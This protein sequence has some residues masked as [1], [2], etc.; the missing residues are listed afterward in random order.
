M[1]LIDLID[2]PKSGPLIGIDPGSK[3]LGI[4]ASDSLRLIASP[5][6]TIQRSKLAKD[7]AALFAL[8]DDRGAV[9]LVIGLPLNMDGSEGPRVQSARALAR[10]IARARDIPIAMQDERLSTAQ[11]TRAMLEADLSR[12]RRAEIIDASAA[13]I[14]LQTALDQLA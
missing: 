11:A 8:Y 1:A 5:V 10:N 12:A 6:T 9:G 14:I 13:A 2:L 3:T 7:L 4:A